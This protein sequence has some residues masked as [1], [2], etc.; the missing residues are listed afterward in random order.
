[1]DKMNREIKKARKRTCKKC[2]GNAE[3]FIAHVTCN[4]C[5]YDED[6]LEDLV[7]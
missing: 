3:L 5:S 1:M 7:L 2:G 6:L 4:D